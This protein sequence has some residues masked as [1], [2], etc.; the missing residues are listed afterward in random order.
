[1]VYNHFPN[2]NKIS[3]CGYEFKPSKKEFTSVT[4]LTLSWQPDK[5]D[6]FFNMFPNL[7]TLT[8]THFDVRA[9][10]FLKNHKNITNLTIANNAYQVNNHKVKI[11]LPTI[12]HLH[13]ESGCVPD[14]LYLPALKQLYVSSIP[15]HKQHEPIQD[16]TRYLPMPSENP[17]N[18]S[19]SLASLLLRSQLI[20]TVIIENSAPINL[21][22]LQYAFSMKTLTL[23]FKP[24]TED[25]FG[26]TKMTNKL[27]KCKSLEHLNLKGIKI[28][29]FS[30]FLRLPKLKTLSIK[31]CGN[32]FSEEMLEAF[33]E[34]GI[35]VFCF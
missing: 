6:N 4:E 17:N 5:E 13:I 22:F 16:N 14:K 21:D 27:L 10:F 28:E 33:E 18:P 30:I 29:D 2:L 8:F 12:T 25:S 11:T 1:M 3:M 35:K 7:T 9:L 15:K 24:S 20:E 32:A 31:N 19:A 23:S 26:T 34:K